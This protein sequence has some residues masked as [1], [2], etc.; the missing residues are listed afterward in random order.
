MLFRSDFAHIQDIEKT[1]VQLNSRLYALELAHS[2]HVHEVI[3]EGV[4]TLPTSSSASGAPIEFDN[5]SGLALIMAAGVP[6]PTGEGP[7]AVLPSRVGT[8]M[9]TVAIPPISPSEFL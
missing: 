9:E 6:Q 7:P 4:P 8:P 2:E 1:I 3:L 5:G